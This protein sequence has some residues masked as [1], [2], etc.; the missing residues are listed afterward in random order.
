MF[1][2]PPFFRTRRALDRWNRRAVARGDRGGAVIWKGWFA[3]AQS[4]AGFAAT[5]V[6]GVAGEVALL[7]WTGEIVAAGATARSA[8]PGGSRCG[9]GAF[10]RVFRRRWRIRRKCFGHWFENTKFD[11]LLLVGDPSEY[12]PLLDHLVETKDWTLRYVDHTSMVFRRD[13]GKAW[14]IADFAPVRARFAK[15]RERDLAEVL[16]QTAIR[17]LA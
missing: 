5:G 10:A 12:K 2:L 14:E 13:S 16:A 6:G 7:Q 1:A 11:A 4:V 9:V 17:L 15:G 3:E 8:D